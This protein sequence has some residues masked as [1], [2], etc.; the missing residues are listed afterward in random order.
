MAPNNNKEIVNW[1]RLMDDALVDAFMNEYNEGHKVNGTFT[2]TAYDNICKYLSA[3]FGKQI[4]KEKVKNRWKTLKKNFSDVYDIFKSLSGFAWNP[5]TQVWDAEP[6]VWDALIE[7]KPKAALW[8]TTPFPNY[9]KMMILYGVDRANGDESETS[10]EWR[11]RRRS[12]EEV[13][14]TVNDINNIVSQNRATINVELDGQENSSRQEN[15][16]DQEHSP[17]INSACSKKTKRVSKEKEASINELTKAVLAVAEAIQQGNVMIGQSFK[18]V[19]QLS[20][21]E[22]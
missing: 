7:A 9:E 10:R 6:E 15:S 16:P 11:K 2:T 22:I 21:E 19:P 8:R 13:T 14:E 5:I 4:D 12:Q 3:L 18:K 17:T 1:T 20:G